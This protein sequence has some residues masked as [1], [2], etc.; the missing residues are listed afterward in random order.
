[1]IIEETDT[2]FARERSFLTSLFPITTESLDQE[3]HHDDGA[4]TIS[5][6]PTLRSDGSPLST[7]SAPSP[8][9]RRLIDLASAD[10]RSED[11]ERD[12]FVF[13]YKKERDSAP[14]TFRVVTYFRLSSY[15]VNG[16]DMRL[17]NMP[18]PGPVL[19]YFMFFSRVYRKMIALQHKD[20]HHAECLHFFDPID[21]T[22]GGLGITEC[23]ECMQ[24]RYDY[25]IVGHIHQ[26]FLLVASGKTT[27]EKWKYK[28]NL[29][30][31]VQFMIAFA[32]IAF[33]NKSFV[34]PTMEDRI[35][36]LCDILEFH[37][38]SRYIRAIL[39]TLFINT[40]IPRVNENI[41]IAEEIKRFIIITTPSYVVN[42][43]KRSQDVIKDP[44]YRLLFMKYFQDLY[45]HPYEQYPLPALDM[46]TVKVCSKLWYRMVIHNTTHQML[47]F[48]INHSIPWLVV[49]VKQGCK[50][51]VA[52]GFSMKASIEINPTRLGAVTGKI[53]VASYT[54][55]KK[56]MIEECSIPIFINVIA[57]RDG[58]GADAS[59]A[60][61]K[62][63]SKAASSSPVKG[64][65]GKRVVKSENELPRL[66][67][68]PFGRMTATR[69]GLWGEAPVIEIPL[70]VY[71]RQN[72]APRGPCASRT[73][74]SAPPSES[75]KLAINWS[76][77][78]P[79]YG[80]DTM[81]S[82]PGHCPQSVGKKEDGGT[83]SCDEML[84]ETMVSS[85]LGQEVS[86][87]VSGQVYDQISAEL[88]AQLDAQLEE[89]IF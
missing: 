46:G 50:T 84:L 23:V 42:V 5:L 11:Q 21:I 30:E 22:K 72:L 83:S 10:A 27:E 2:T 37:R 34:C 39:N 85:E 81:R 61:I 56:R 65:R 8:V 25:F 12:K 19:L 18:Q 9:V 47:T 6:S 35:N 36:R 77:S 62:L 45:C 75:K 70:D 86:A 79:A 80:G 82:H 54:G 78:S 69:P 14:T 87:D 51:S 64:M 68:L 33:C 44:V 58:Q 24:L 60:M 74:L 7:Y 89:S 4:S 63:K 73:T 26:A 88:D 59:A 31:F 32:D 15:Q 3:E 13:M 57:G 17:N 1:M 43:P 71:D 16:I 76:S 53:F 48:E 55:D 49:S 52:P 41:D 66:S 20:A 67:I 40:F 38:G 28:L 29:E